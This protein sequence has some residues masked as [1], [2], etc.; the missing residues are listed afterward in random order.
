MIAASPARTYRTL[1]TAVFPQQTLLRH[2]ALIVA[3]ALFIGVCAQIS[4]RIGV[5]P[6]PITMQP[7]A[8]LLAGGLLGPRL[9]MASAALYVVLGL[10]GLPMYA[11]Q[12]AK[13]GFDEAGSISYGWSILTGGSGGYLMSYPFVTALVGC[14]AERGWDR[15]PVKLAAAMLAG[16]VLIYAFGLPWLY[17]WGETNPTLSGVAGMDLATTLKWGLL[18]FIPGDLAKLVLAA[19][20]VP[21]GWQIFRVLHL[22]HADEREAAPATM[23]LAPLGIA[24]GVAMAVGAI[25]PWA[26][27]DAGV[28]EAAGVVVL[29]AGLA[30]VASSAL[31]MR[32]LIGPGVAQ[33]SIFAAGALGG[34]IAFVHLVEFTTTGELSLASFGAGVPVAVVS[35]LLLFGVSASE[36]AI[37]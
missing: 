30:A 35:A 9:G 25:L 36:R 8:I 21:S 12:F 10:F 5:S 14:L 31:R 22:R 32:R 19:G 28:A 16:N 33:I 27:G 6:V 23:P 29:L 37:E 24:A 34:L 1:G 2:A 18:P 7:F 13:V 26:D 3:S 4:I 15:T 11:G 17:A 20:L